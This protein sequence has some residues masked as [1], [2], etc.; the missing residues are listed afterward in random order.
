MRFRSTSVCRPDAATASRRAMRP[1]VLLAVI[2]VIAWPVTA[3][4]APVVGFVEDWSGVSLSGWNGGTAISNPGTG[5]LGGDGDGFL[6][7]STTLNSNYG[8]FSTGP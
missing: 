1:W 2:A 5:G 4:G 6:Q 3:P 8:T 7:L